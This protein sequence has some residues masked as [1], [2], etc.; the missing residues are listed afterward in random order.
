MPLDC[1]KKPVRFGHRWAFPVDR[2][3]TPGPGGRLF[4]LWT[5]P[6]VTMGVS[7]KEDDW[8]SVSG[9][10]E[11]HPEGRDDEVEILETI[12]FPLAGEKRGQ[13]EL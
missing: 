4:F 13:L 2:D 5:F 6:S 3:R 10:D 12:Q 7:D 1:R 11:G 8:N 9:D